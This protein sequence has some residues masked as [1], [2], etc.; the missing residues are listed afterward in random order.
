MERTPEKV[1]KLNELLRADLGSNPRYAWRWSDDLLHVMD[2]VDSEGL[3]EYVES[4]SPAGLIIMTPKTVTRQLLPF[5]EHC[6]VLC[7]LVE[8]TKKDGE[9]EST[10]LASWVPVGGGNGP[11][12]LYPFELPNIESTQYIV[13]MIRQQRT[14]TVLEM[15]QEWNEEMAKREKSSWNR[16]YDQIREQAT[17]FYNV[18]GRKGHVSFGGLVQ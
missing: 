7:A 5:H 16:A 18:P 4:K 15:G 17:A 1:R 9:L 14:K 3:P 2:V 12:A 10:G 11:V 13:N 8:T 6:W